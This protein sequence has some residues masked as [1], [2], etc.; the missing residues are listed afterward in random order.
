MLVEAVARHLALPDH[1]HDDL[2]GVDLEEGRDGVV[3]VH[4]REVPGGHRAH[5]DPVHQHVGYVPAGS[6]G[7]GVGLVGPVVHGGGAGRGDGAGAGG[8]GGQGVGVDLEEGGDGDVRVGGEA[9][10]GVGREEVVVLVVPAGEV[11]A[12]VGGGGE[13]DQVAVLVEAVARHLALPDHGH[14]DLVGVDLEEGRDGVVGVHVREVPGG[15]R[16]HRDPVHQHVG[17]VPAGSGGDGVGLVGPVVHGGG[18]GRGD[19][20]GAGGRGGQG[21]GVDLEEGGD[22]DVRV[23]GEAVVGVGREEVVVLVVPAGEVPAGVG[24]GGELDQ[25]AVLVEAVARHLALPDHGHDDLVG[26]DLEEGR[27][28]VVGVHVREV[29]GGHRAHR[30]PVH[31]HV[32]YVPAGS[33]GDGVGLVGPVVHGGGAGR[34]DGAG[35][36]GRGGQGVGVDGE[37]HHHRMV[38]RHAIDHVRVRYGGRC[39][40]VGDG[41]DVVSGIW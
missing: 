41:S 35:A 18:A 33:G 11:P 29:P 12:G 23:G 6:G 21:V 38:D 25:V 40:V 2:V 8:R 20:A 3:G 22:G 34:G 9:V 10:V 32:G 36:G 24:G 26:V 37:R 1:G 28:G 17:Y 5:R 14:D 19:G 13:L 31:Q 30:D 27:D 16:A 15:H 4:V 7:D 39:P